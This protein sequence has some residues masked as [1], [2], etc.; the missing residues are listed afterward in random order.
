MNENDKII[1]VG[2][3]GTEDKPFVIAYMCALDYE[4]ELA[5]TSCRVYPSIQAHRANCSCGKNG[6]VEVAVHYVRY[7]E[8]T[9]VNDKSGQ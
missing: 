4:Y 6:S 1:P 8:N 2:N 7:V 9:D 3:A 5:A